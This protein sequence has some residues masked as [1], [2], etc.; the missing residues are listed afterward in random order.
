MDSDGEAD[1][2][3]SPIDTVDPEIE[4]EYVGAH[5][6]VTNDECQEWED[7]EPEADRFVPTQ[8]GDEATHT[9]VMKS[10]N[11]LHEIAMCDGCGEP[12]DVTATDREWSA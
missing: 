7:A 9:V 1:R 6:G 10:E 5:S 8:C 2:K 12:D 11:G 4:P 3:G